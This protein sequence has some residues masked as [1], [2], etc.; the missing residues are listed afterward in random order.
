M[1]IS[2]LDRKNNKSKSSSAFLIG[3]IVGA[4]GAY[5]FLTENGASTRKKIVEKAK[6]LSTDLASRLNLSGQSFKGVAA[7]QGT[8]DNAIVSTSPDGTNSSDKA[9]NMVNH[10]TQTNSDPV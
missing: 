5:F 7:H 4:V 2:S 6:D 8:T 10:L 1:F 9:H 3:G